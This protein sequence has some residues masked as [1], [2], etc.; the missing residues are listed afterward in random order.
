MKIA[1]YT[2]CKN[3]KQFV[4]RWLH[5]CEEA[6]YISI[7][8]TGSTDGTQDY[9]NE[10]LQNRQHPQ[11]HV[12][13]L[14]IKPWRFDD[15]RAFNLH[16]IPS[17]VDVCICLDMDEVL[18][19]GWREVIEEAWHEGLDRLRYNY[20]WSWDGDK[21]AVTYFADK[22]H[23][24]FGFRWTHPVHEVL[25]KDSRLGPE[26]Q[27]FIP[28]T[29]I[30]HYPDNTKPRSQYLPLLA[31]SVKEMPHDDRNAHY[32]ARELFFDGQYDL[33]IAEFYRHLNLP[34]ATWD[35]ERAASLRYLGDCYWAKGEQEAAIENFILAC[36][37]VQGEREP[38]ISLAQAYR[39]RGEW[40]LCKS[41]LEEAL[42]ITSRANS[43]ISQPYAWSDWPETMLREANEHLNT[44]N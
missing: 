32:Y 15:A 16:L 10:I 24:R 12:A 33:A 36:Q 29:L 19:P 26:V 31:L 1:V 35:S 25:V 3:E 44:K 40:A 4:D 38:R 34:T 22:I 11:L 2:I 7:V 28:N 8:D 41:V 43:Y 18:T 30:E 14:V 39:A 23:A 37:L 21:P 20:V 42:K 5:S 27:K 9:L 6:D 13:D 17:D